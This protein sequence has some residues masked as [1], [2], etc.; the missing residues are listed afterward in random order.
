MEVGG[1]NN[2]ITAYDLASHKHC[3]ITRVIVSVV[4]EY[5]F[6]SIFLCFPP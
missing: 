6:L 4:I 5:T 3:V 1:K 2:N